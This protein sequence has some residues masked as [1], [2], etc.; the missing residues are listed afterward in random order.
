MS[1][2]RSRA[3]RIENLEKTILSSAPKKISKLCICGP[4]CFHSFREFEAMIKRPCPVHG[5][6][7][8]TPMFFANSSFPLISDDPCF[9]QED[10]EAESMHDYELTPTQRNERYQQ[11]LRAHEALNAQ[12]LENLEG[13]KK[14]GRSPS[15]ADWFN[16]YLLT[17][18]K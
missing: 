2:A 6:R 15:W 11:K 9:C 8:I 10:A 4:C 7:D 14:A 17:H 3:K 5:L 16:D 1:E 13:S 12:Y 18:A